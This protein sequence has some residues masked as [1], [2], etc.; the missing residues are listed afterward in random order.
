M[1]WLTSLT[2][3]NQEQIQYIWP[4]TLRPQ[5]TGDRRKAVKFGERN[6]PFKNGV[7]SEILQPVKEH[8]TH[9][10]SSLF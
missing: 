10:L 1:R 5:K 6:N 2:A 4:V 9:F 7:I 8:I 3:V